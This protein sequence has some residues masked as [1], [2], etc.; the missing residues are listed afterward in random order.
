MRNTGAA[1]DDTESVPE[2]KA[3]YQMLYEDTKPMI[4]PRLQIKDHET[5]KKYLAMHNYVQK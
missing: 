3:R 4:I 1:V 2:D 5:S